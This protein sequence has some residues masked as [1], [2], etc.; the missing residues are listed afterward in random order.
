VIPPR[1]PGFPVFG[2]ASVAR[3][4][5]LPHPVPRYLFGRTFVRSSSLRAYRTVNLRL[6][7]EPLGETRVAD[8][9]FGRGM[10][11]VAPLGE[12]PTVESDVGRGL[13]HV[14]PLG[15]TIV[16]LADFGRG[17]LQVAP[18]GE[19]RAAGSCGRAVSS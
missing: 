8:L 18:L 12:T 16:A 11:Q 19:T 17:L 3:L 2:D 10:L 13:L 9:D 1:S 7:T 15:E 14:A 5:V 6:Q 4:F